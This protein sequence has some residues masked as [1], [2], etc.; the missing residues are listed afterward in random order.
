[1]TATDET[2]RAEP[3]PAPPR[4]ATAGAGDEPVA[5]AGVLPVATS[6]QTRATIRAAGR[7]HR[8]L[9]V[10]ALVVLVGA[11]IAAL[12]VPRLVGALVD[13][14]VEG[15]SASDLDRTVLALAVATLAQ[16][17]LA[18]AGLAVA[19]ALSERF[20]A[21][22][23]EDVVD[24]ALALPLAEVERGGTGDLVARV[25]G[26]VDAVGEAIRLALPEMVVSALVIGLTVVG[27]GALDWRLAVAGLL[28][29]P[30]QIATTRRYLRRSGP[31]YAAE[32]AADG[33]RAQ[34]VHASVAGARAVRVLGLGPTHVRRLDDASQATVDLAVATAR[35]R[36]W[37]HVGLNAAELVG[38][39]AILVTGFLLVRDD[40]ITLGMATAAALYFHR[41]F[42]PIGIVLSQLDHAQAAWAALAR[43]VGVA[44]LGASTAAATPAGEDAP[45]R[46]ADGP[47]R[48]ANTPTPATVEL[49]GVDFAYDGG[50]PV[51]P[52]GRSAPRARRAGRPGR[53]VRR[54]ARPRS[55]SSSRAS[56]PRAPA[57]CG[58]TAPRSSS[59]AR[60]RWGAGSRS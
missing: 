33:R 55:P 48:P 19:G 41:L 20:L 50:P 51:L 59:S 38:M 44:S 49:A 3:D 40:T 18:G 57:R 1:M 5:A 54:R 29:V 52:R 6:A 9:V 56:T 14:V 47:D 21:G 2:T 60:R 31:I 30:F 23:R 42:D 34:R 15:R 46:R 26:D 22:L 8:G 36:A 4:P 37:F 10:A 39:A 25:V 27:L 32:R 16:G 45:A 58:S 11:T 13:V 43:L 7:H 53:G 28:A 35:E 24:T 17:V 12:A